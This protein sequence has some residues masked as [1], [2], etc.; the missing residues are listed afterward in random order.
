[1]LKFRNR[2]QRQDRE[3][4]TI[5]QTAEGSTSQLYTRI[6][7][8]EQEIEDLKNEKEAL[9]KSGVNRPLSTRNSESTEVSQ[10]IEANPANDMASLETA[11]EKLRAHG[12]VGDDAYY[13]VFEDYKVAVG[14]EMLK[15]K[16][17]LLVMRQENDM[18]KS[19]SLDLRKKDEMLDALRRQ[20]EDMDY[21]KGIM[22]STQKIEQ[23]RHR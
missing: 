3:L 18:L 1:L 23:G 17:N 10:S 20:V 6:S 7:I 13:K 21:E 12:G 5:K 19:A 2:I 11:M 16:K 9:R 4:E 14:R 8:L 22:H 15:M